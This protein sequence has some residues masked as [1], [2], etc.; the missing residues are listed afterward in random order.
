MT[1]VATIPNAQRKRLEFG[2]DHMNRRISKVVKTW[3]GGAFTSPVTNLFVYDGWNLLAVLTSDR[4]LLTSFAW[5]ND[6]S[7][8]MGEAGGIGGLLLVTTHGSPG[9][10]AFVGY[11]GIGDV[12]ALVNSVSG[13]VEARYEFSPFGQPT[14]ATGPIAAVN[15]F[16]FGTKY[17]DQETGLINYGYRYYDPVQGKWLARDPAAENGGNNLHAFVA[18]NP[19]NFVEIGGAIP[20]PLISIGEFHP[21]KIKVMESWFHQNTRASL[22]RVRHFNE[23]VEGGRE[24]GQMIGIGAVHLFE[25]GLKTY[26]LIRHHDKAAEDLATN[27]LD[28]YRHRLAGDVAWADLDA[29]G[30][31]ASLIEMSGDYVLAYAVLDRLLLMN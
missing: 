27:G 14:R 25:A 24:W 23:V 31:A 6:L 12:T 15:P 18:N 26:E 3:N 29:V 22:Q 2:Y 8:T 21:D 13:A 19:V 9:T 11:D 5:G 20:K 10:N 17:C 28:F 1:N 4:G 30:V 16:R 7:G